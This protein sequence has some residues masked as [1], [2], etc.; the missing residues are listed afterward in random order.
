MELIRRLQEHC[1]LPSPDAVPPERRK[2]YRAITADLTKVFEELA[3][4]DRPAIQHLCSLVRCLVFQQ[5]KGE[6]A[7]SVG[8]LRETVRSL[9]TGKSD[10]YTYAAIVRHWLAAL[11]SLPEQQGR[12]VADLVEQSLDALVAGERLRTLAFVRRLFLKVGK[13]EFTAKTGITLDVINKRRDLQTVMSVSH[14][15]GVAQ[16]TGELAVPPSTWTREPGVARAR[17]AWQQDALHVL[18]WEPQAATLTGWIG[19]AG[20][21]ETEATLTGEFGIPVAEAK[22]L[23]R[24]ETVAP[25]TAMTIVRTLTE[26]GTMDQA[27]AEELQRSCQLKESNDAG[28]V[29]EKR[30]RAAFER[31]R[32]SFN[33][34]A[35][36]LRLREEFPDRK[37]RIDEV[38][39]HAV[40]HGQ[41]RGSACP[42]L[43]AGIAARSQE[44]FDALFR[45]GRTAFEQS[46]RRSGSRLHPLYI[47]RIAHGVR[48]QDLAPLFTEDDL[49]R[50]ERHRPHAIKDI[51]D[52]ETAVVMAGER[53][54]RRLLARWMEQHSLQT[55]AGTT[56]TLCDKIGQQELAGRAKMSIGGLQTMIRG[57]SVPTLP[58]VEAV[59]EGG[60]AALTD[61]LVIDWQLQR[62]EQGRRLPLFARCLDVCIASRWT[63]VTEFLRHAGLPVE[64]Y[65]ALW[66]QIRRGLR[67]GPS[68]TRFVQELQTGPGDSAAAFLQLVL[69]EE[70]TDLAL[71]EWMQ[72]MLQSGR[73]DLAMGIGC[74]RAFLEARD[75][76]RETGLP[77]LR[78]L[79]K[80]KFAVERQLDPLRAAAS[81]ASI[82]EHKARV[83]LAQTPGIL[84]SDILH[85]RPRG[86]VATI[87]RHARERYHMQKMTDDAET[88]NDAL[89][90]VYDD[91]DP[92]F[93]ARWGAWEPQL[94]RKIGESLEAGESD[95][96]RDV[97]A[98]V[99]VYTRRV[100]DRRE[101]G[102]RYMIDRKKNAVED[103]RA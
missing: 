51:R 14:L 83:A 40:K 44:E 85:W 42:L 97:V 45:T 37:E 4:V 35:E 98:A 61:P 38:V 72:R 12:L 31:L 15:L 30:V 6:Y 73:S 96:L 55:V 87:F 102:L 57:R 24:G 64:S 81:A 67:R 41:F 2:A 48:Y 21:P 71:Y 50:L 74:L 68:V 59:I 54:L 13:E 82:P 11:P 26:R 16:K 1:A 94:R 91:I 66:K 7:A 90:L 9:E 79:L 34:V 60:G 3:R 29:F 58:Q 22:R 5:T 92:Y 8:V 17:D 88:V 65:R 47:D 76:Q 93:R 100:I 103:E 32:L 78:L 33:D 89:T 49:Q 77:P 10:E 56:R 20:Y 99:L 36:L 70:S 95:T 101:G 23:L 63:S 80:K 43:L 25:E 19:S 46:L 84:A 28:L 62:A 39:R 52:A 86:T 27:T 18:T 75:I 53:K 69:R